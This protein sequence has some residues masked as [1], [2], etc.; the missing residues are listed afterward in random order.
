[1]DSISKIRPKQAWGAFEKNCVLALDP[2]F[3]TVTPHPQPFL[4]EGYPNG[5]GGESPSYSWICGPGMEGN[6]YE[7][8]VGVVG[9]RRNGGGGKKEQNVFALGFH[10]DPKAQFIFLKEQ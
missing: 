3:P 5:G 10:L 9:Q 6:N 7:K 8:S 1:M 2:A 4:T